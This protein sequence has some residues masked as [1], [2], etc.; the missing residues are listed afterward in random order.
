MYIL[1]TVKKVPEGGFKTASLQQCY[2]GKK[3]KIKYPKL[4]N[5]TPTDM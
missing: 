3:K 5:L 1:K 4:W 2:T